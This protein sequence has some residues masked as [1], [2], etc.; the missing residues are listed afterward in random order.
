L[1]ALIGFPMQLALVSSITVRTSH[2][3]HSWQHYRL[4][5]LM[6]ASIWNLLMQIQQLWY[7]TPCDLD[8]SV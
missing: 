4:G 1:A 2:R 3:H 8:T 7:G 5:G 6:F